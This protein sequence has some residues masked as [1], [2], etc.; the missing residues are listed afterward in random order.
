MYHFNGFPMELQI[1]FDKQEERSSF[2]T[3]YQADKETCYYNRGLPNG[4]RTRGDVG[5][6]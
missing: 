4:H 3:E 5:L 2:S 6:I 1:E